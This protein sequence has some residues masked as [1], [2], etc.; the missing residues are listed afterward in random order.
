MLV[1]SAIYVR[2]L[3]TQDNAL[4]VRFAIYVRQLATQDSALSV[5]F[6][7][8]VRRVWRIS[9]RPVRFVIVLRIVIYATFVCLVMFVKLHN[10][11]KE[12]KWVIVKFVI[13]VKKEWRIL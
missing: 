13:I 6:A 3:A 2:Q 1:S 7:M 11:K 9:A 12:K 10:R 5:R 4:S 8:C